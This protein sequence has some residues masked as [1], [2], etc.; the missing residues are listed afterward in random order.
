MLGAEKVSRPGVYSGYS[1]ARYDGWV[2]SSQY[3]TVKD[4]TRLAVDIFRP[5]QKG[6]AFRLRVPL[7]LEPTL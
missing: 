4:G 6:A 5:A 2:K 7:V 3:V 1:E